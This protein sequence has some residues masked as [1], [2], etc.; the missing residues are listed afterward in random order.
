M[1]EKNNGGPAFPLA[2]SHV[3]LEHTNWA[4]ANGATLRDYF[5]AKA[6]PALIARVGSHIDMQGRYEALNEGLA[7]TAYE[8][9]DAM[10]KARDE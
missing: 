1:S 4:H 10:L 7:I 9:A 5:A 8:L 6:L 2:H 3:D